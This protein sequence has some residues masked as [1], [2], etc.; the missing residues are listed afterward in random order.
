MI[1]LIAQFGPWLVGVIGAIA[2]LFFHQQAKTS[3]A[4]ADQKVAEA[5]R[6]TAE[7]KAAAAKAGAD[8]AKERINVENDIASRPAS[9]AA[10]QL[11]DRWSAD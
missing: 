2:A 1:A 10:K 4:E 8:S 7:T 11:H 9:D 5:N 6:K 3:K